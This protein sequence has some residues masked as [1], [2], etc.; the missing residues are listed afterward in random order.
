MWENLVC[1]ETMHMVWHML[2]F[3]GN[4]IIFLL[5][6]CLVG[7]SL[8]ETTAL[9][10]LH[11]LV[12]YV[13][14]VLLRIGFLQCSRPILRLIHKEKEAVSFADAMVMAWGGLRGAVGLALAIQ[15]ADYSKTGAMLSEKDG[16]RVLFYTGGVAFLTL[17]VNA[18]TCPLLVQR[19]GITKSLSSQVKL[20]KSVS[21][22]LNV[23]ITENETDETTRN[24]GLETMEHIKHDIN[25]MLKNA[26]DTR[27]TERVISSSGWSRTPGKVEVDMAPLTEMSFWLNDLKD[28]DLDIARV[29]N[30]VPALKSIMETAKGVQKDYRRLECE[31]VDPELLEAVR[32]CFLR[33]VLH[34]Y[35]HELE[36]ERVT[37]PIFR[38]LY[39]SVMEALAQSGARQK[40]AG[41]FL[42]V[43]KKLGWYGVIENSDSEDDTEVTVAPVIGMSIAQKNWKKVKMNVALVTMVGRKSVEGVDGVDGEASTVSS[44][45]PSDLMNAVP[46]PAA[47]TSAASGLEGAAPAKKRVSATKQKIDLPKRSEKGT[48]VTACEHGVFWKIRHSMWYMVLMLAAIMGTAICGAIEEM[49]VGGEMAFLVL[50][51]IFNIIFTFE[52]V[53]TLLDEKLLYVRHPMNY[54]DLTLVVLGWVGVAFTISNLG[55]QSAAAASETSTFRAVK[56]LKSLR[57]LRVFRLVRAYKTLQKKLRGAQ[58]NDEVARLMEIRLTLSTFCNAHIAAQAA[59][60]HFL[61]CDQDEVNNIVEQCI[62]ESLAAIFEAVVVLAQ[63]HEGMEPWILDELATCKQSKEIAVELMHFIEHAQELGVLSSRE[64]ASIQHGAFLARFGDHVRRTCSCTPSATRSRCCRSR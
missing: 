53:V 56:V 54:F 24:N 31:L 5:A 28:P 10:W 2:E 29:M 17:I 59:L 57:I 25:K 51:C 62:V 15:V 46:A 16:R 34:T 19:L 18:M 11:L 27:S 64:A 12:I 8:A 44:A 58:L 7:A 48:K 36:M 21:S 4:T 14:L 23:H 50:E 38:M 43:K 22:S 47:R 6:G 20:M 3:L 61:L 60:R 42:V 63:P 13:F 26:R 41:D 37:T 55:S 35:W 40:G 9:E 1:K 49:E 39:S 32:K 33:I 45:P 30:L 52:V